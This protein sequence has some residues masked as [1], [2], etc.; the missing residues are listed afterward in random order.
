MSIHQSEERATGTPAPGTTSFNFVSLATVDQ[1][2]RRRENWSFVAAFL[3][4]VLVT[5]GVSFVWQRVYDL[6]H[7][8][9][10]DAA[11]VSGTMAAITPVEAGTVM[12]VDAQVGSTVHAGQT[13]VT[14]RRANGVRMR[15]TSPI[16]GTI[17]QEGATPGEVLPARQPL[18]QVVD[19]GRLSITAYVEESHIK[20]IAAGQSADVMVDAFGGT[21]FHGKVRRIVLGDDG[22][23]SPATSGA[24]AN[25]TITDTA[26]RVPVEIT[27]DSYPGRTLYPG[28]SAAVAIYIK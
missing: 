19:L 15:L 26:Q 1:A 28:E 18:A 20:D 24:Y 17:I 5:W 23:P 27:L 2:R 4:L 6:H 13:I 9:R 7:T 11:T 10:T 21:T 8:Y 3:G 12:A 16:N 22:T 25:G 14:L